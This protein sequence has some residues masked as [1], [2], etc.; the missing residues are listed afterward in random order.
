MYH[1]LTTALTAS[2][3]KLIHCFLHFHLV[4]KCFII[5]VSVFFLKQRLFRLF[6]NFKFVNI[7]VVFPDMILLLNSSVTLLWSESICCMISVCLNILRLSY[8]PE[9]DVPWWMSYVPLNLTCILLL[10]N[11][12]FQIH[13]LSQVGLDVDQFC[14]VF[15]YF[16][17]YFI[18]YW[19]R[20]VEISKY[21]CGFVYSFL[22]FYQF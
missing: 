12:V 11:Y 6:L 17:I 16:S 13:Q 18:N 4:Q 10:L 15:T 21:N 14:S 1:S 9:Y 7:S 2:C 8:D 20:S 19:E 22:Q 5:S 3:K